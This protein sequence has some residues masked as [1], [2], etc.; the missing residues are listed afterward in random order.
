MYFTK[1][2]HLL[3]RETQLN[4]EISHHFTQLLEK[5]ALKSSASSPGSDS[6]VTDQLLMTGLMALSH[7]RGESKPSRVSLAWSP[8]MNLKPGGET[9]GQ[10]LPV[11]LPLLVF[12]EPTSC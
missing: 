2:T 3:K 8:P 5:F 4:K 1:I 12:M 10:L 7:T 6:R 9:L 11:H